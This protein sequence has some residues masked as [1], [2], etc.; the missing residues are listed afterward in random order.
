ML[1]SSCVASQV[2]ASEEGLSCMKS[3]E[4][5][6]PCLCI[7]ITRILAFLLLLAEVIVQPLRERGHVIVTLWRRPLRHHWKVTG[8]HFRRSE[9][10]ADHWVPCNAKIRNAGSCTSTHVHITESLIFLITHSLIELSPSWEAANCAATQELPEF[11]GTRRFIAVFT[12]AVHWSLFWARSNQ[13]IPS[14]PISLR[15]ILILSTHL[16]LGLPSCLLPSGIP[17]NIW[18]VI[19]I[20]FIV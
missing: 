19:I 9:C 18:S 14:H 4:S 7:R 3:V 15:S 11:Y 5:L 10:D 13:S 12:R 2:A 6:V 8:F 16:R 17:T 20:Q 1:G